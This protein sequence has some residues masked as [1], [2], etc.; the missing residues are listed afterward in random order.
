MKRTH[1]DAKAKRKISRRILYYSFIPIICFAP[2]I[3]LD[4]VRAFKIF[5]MTEKMKD[6]LLLMNIILQYSWEFLNLWFY[7]VLI[8]NNN[9]DQVS[10]DSSSIRS[11]VSSIESTLIRKKTTVIVQL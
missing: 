8:P 6:V 5:A 11:S 2:S 9:Q 10:E 3:F 4:T 1:Y 7:W